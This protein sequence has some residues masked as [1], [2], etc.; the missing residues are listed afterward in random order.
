VELFA[1]LTGILIGASAASLVALGWAASE[2]RWLAAHCNYQIAYWRNE[3]GRARAAAAWLREQQAADRPGSA[4]NS[5]WSS[6]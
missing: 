4:P 6:R 5:L 2:L 1:M 3:A